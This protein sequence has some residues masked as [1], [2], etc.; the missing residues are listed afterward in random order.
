MSM[1]CAQPTCIGFRCKGQ[2]PGFS[3]KYCAR[4]LW[5]GLADILLPLLRLARFIFSF[6]IC[7]DF[8]VAPWPLGSIAAWYRL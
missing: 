6:L 8:Q 5:Q 2:P 1:K 7:T 4:D 3:R